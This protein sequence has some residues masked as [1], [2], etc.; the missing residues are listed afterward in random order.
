M[1]VLNVV[2]SLRRGGGIEHLLLRMLGAIRALEQRPDWRAEGRAAPLQ[3]EICYIGRREPE[4]REPFAEIGVPVW[5]CRE[6][7]VP[8]VFARRF[9]AALRSRGSYDVIHTHNS[10]FG[11]PALR[12]ARRLGV[13][14]RL[15][16]YHNLTSGHANDPMRR[17][18]EKWLA[19]QVL[20]H[21]TGVCA[22]ASGVLR[23]R[24]G[25]AMLHDP[26][27]RVIP[28]AIELDGSWADDAARASMRTA[29]RRELGIPADALVIGH[30]G[31]FVPQKNHAGLMEV[32]KRVFEREPLSQL[33]LVG[34]GPLR[35]DI[36][37][38]TAALGISARC[39]FAGV[40]SDI[41]AMYAAMDVFVL[42]SREEGLG[43]VLIEAQAAGLPVVASRLATTDDAIAPVAQR[44]IR[45]RDDVAGLAEALCSAIEFVRAGGAPLDALRSSARAFAAR[46]TPAAAAGALLSAWGV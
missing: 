8:G 1:R 42:P 31:R 37:R 21:A 2:G 17:W 26:R 39:R 25:Q 29:A 16:H 32:A 43:V 41:A 44:W 45:A 11:A 9:S 6:S 20:R 3:I 5:R 28:A 10:N 30:V 33:L 36:E 7:F 4:L 38:R 19:S 12:A 22:V 15:A 34:D 35:P 23:A 40:R 14:V 24:F 13:P 27:A 18:M 46:F